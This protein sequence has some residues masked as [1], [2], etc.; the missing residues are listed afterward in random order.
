MEAT[1]GV[2]WRLPSGN[3]SSELKTAPGR[4]FGWQAVENGK[5]EVDPTPWQGYGKTPARQG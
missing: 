2:K 1:A 5:H 4:L 3:I